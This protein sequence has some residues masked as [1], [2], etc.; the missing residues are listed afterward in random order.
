MTEAQLIPITESYIIQSEEGLEKENLK[1][2]FKKKWY[3]LKDEGEINEFIK[4]TSAI[5]NTVGLDGFIIIG[6]DDA[7]K[8]FQIQNFQTVALKIP[9]N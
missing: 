9:M 6:F 3:N 8:E 7:E 4:D 2:D 1:F 5:A